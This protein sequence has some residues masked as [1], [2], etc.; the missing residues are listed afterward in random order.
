MIHLNSVT[1]Y[2]I[3]TV[4]I[5]TTDANPP[6]SHAA[7]QRAVQLCQRG[8]TYRDTVAFVDNPVGYEDI[9]TEIVNIPQ[10]PNYRDVCPFVLTKL[11]D[12]ILPLMG[13]HALKCEWDGFVLN[14]KCWT[15]DFLEWDYIGS[16]FFG[17][18]VGNMGFCLQSQRYFKALKEL[19]L[20][21]TEF[22]CYP[23][24]QKICIENRANMEALGVRF[25]PVEL[26]NRFA[27]ENSPPYGTETLGGHGR[28]FLA[29]VARQGRY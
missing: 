20:P 21:A 27:R 4:P 9:A 6:A 22:A 14:P 7:N 10:F 23:S 24:D 19:N 13:S 29:D 16:P 8:L 28:L 1:L 26:A 5:Q 17:H 25:A 15:D 11:P 18:T 12:L 3:Q 2:T